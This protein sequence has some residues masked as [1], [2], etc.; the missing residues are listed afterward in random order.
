MLNNLTLRAGLRGLRALGHTQNQQGHFPSVQ[1]S[2]PRPLT[3]A[4]SHPSPTRASSRRSSESTSLDTLES[5]PVTLSSTSSSTS[6]IF[7]RLSTLSRSN[8]SLKEAIHRPEPIK[9]GFLDRRS[10]QLPLDKQKLTISKKILHLLNDEEQAVQQD[11][12][13][14]VQNHLANLPNPRV[15][16]LANQAVDFFNNG[17]SKTL[18]RWLL[19]DLSSQQPEHFT[20]AQGLSAGLKSYQGNLEAVDDFLNQAMESITQQLKSHDTAAVP[21]KIAEAAQMLKKTEQDVHDYRDALHHLILQPSE[22][23]V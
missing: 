15:K 18:R 2:R 4:A 7:R 20:N 5:H 14:L 9:S 23:R 3:F 13:Q 21:P 1:H 17:V 10:I 22:L 12:Q 11:F 8:Q 19:Q 6:N 16:A